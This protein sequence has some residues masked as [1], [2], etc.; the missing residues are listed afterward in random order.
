MFQDVLT[1]VAWMGGRRGWRTGRREAQGGG[2]KAAREGG[3]AELTEKE[4]TRGALGSGGGLLGLPVRTCV[5]ATL[6]R[7]RPCYVLRPS[8][9]WSL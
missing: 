1:A 6:A 9:V 2:T 5:A 4:E 3:G 8:C 7:V